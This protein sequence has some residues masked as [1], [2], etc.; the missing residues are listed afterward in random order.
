M[1][2]RFCTQKAEGLWCNVKGVILVTDNKIVKVGD[3]C[4]Y[5]YDNQDAREK[6]L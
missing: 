5:F 1:V 6:G 4:A 3:V 2:Y